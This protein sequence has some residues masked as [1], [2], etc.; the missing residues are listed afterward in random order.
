MGSSPGRLSPAGSVW[1]LPAPEP[2]PGLATALIDSTHWL[3]SSSSEAWKRDS[4]PLE[5][6]EKLRENVKKNL[7]VLTK[8]VKFVYSLQPEDMPLFRVVRG[9]FGSA[10]LQFHR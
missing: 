1:A 4:P 6:L 3:I 9:D 7:H 8:N 5:S 10:T 2:D